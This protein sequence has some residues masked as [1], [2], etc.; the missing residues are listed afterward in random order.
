MQSALF[1]YK[2]RQESE[3]WSNR[4]SSSQTWGSRSSHLPC[5]HRS[6]RILTELAI[7]RSKYYKTWRF[8]LVD[9]SS[10]G[11]VLRLRTFTSSPADTFL[12][13]WSWQEHKSTETRHLSLFRGSRQAFLSPSVRSPWSE[14]SVPPPSHPTHAGVSKRKAIAKLFNRQSTS[15]LTQTTFS[16]SSMLASSTLSRHLCA[17]APRSS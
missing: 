4:F 14:V 5:W 6:C 17:V 3:K 11:H 10:N 1:S 9:R 2:T 16:G 8:S 15:S 12:A 13:M 7:S